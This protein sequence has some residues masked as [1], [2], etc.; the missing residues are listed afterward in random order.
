VRRREFITL[1]GGTAACPF[2]VHAQ[3]GERMRRMGLLLVADAEPL[4]PFREALGRLGYFEGK[5]IEIEVRS[6]QGQDTRLPE[7]AAELV[8]SRVDVIVA[9]Q[10]P[11]AHAAKNATRDIP[12]VVMA[13][14]P[15]A[16]GLI[17][18]LARPEGNLTGMSATAAEAATKSLELI[19]EI[20]PGARRVGV[21]GN[22]D[23]PFMIPFFEQIERGAPGVR[24]EAHQIIVRSI[25]ELNSAF[26]AIA[27]EGA[28]AVVI[29]G[30][31]PV[32]PTVDL[33]LK[34]RLPSLST[35]KSAVQAGIL[36][37]YSASLRERAGVIASYVDQILKGARPAD[38]PV[39]QPTRYEL[40]MNLKTARTLGLNVPAMLLAR[41]DEVIE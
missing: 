21:L 10:T 8:R 33:A 16:T 30:S 1:I 41:A 17:S 3:Q 23:D 38:L 40:T 32:K 14:D 24:L 5:N 12:I 2:A 11:S 18:N 29:Q 37:S 15:I 4:G 34:Y 22:A 26:A 27:R 39:Q 36:M 28:D 35:Q 9:V 25:D 20:I 6:A 31:L 13:G 19:R 7:L